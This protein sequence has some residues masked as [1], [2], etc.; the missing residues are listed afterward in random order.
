MSRRH[1]RRA[2]ALVACALAVAVPSRRLAAQRIELTPFAGWRAFGD[3]S[4]LAITDDVAFGGLVQVL[5]RSGRAGVEFLYSRQSTAFRAQGQ[6]TGAV[7]SRVGLSVEHFAVS[8][9]LRPEADTSARGGYA[10]FGAGW[11]TLASA[12]YGTVTRPMVTFGAGWRV[13]I[14]P[15]V[16]LHTGVRG[17]LALTSVNDGFGCR[18]RSSDGCVVPFGSSMLFQGE[19]FLGASVGF[20]RR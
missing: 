16:A 10:S 14:V 18:G 13:P 19:A 5:P 12:G 4:D 11:S 3:A 2:A 15:L 9:V 7:P 8:A 1:V 6:V 20:D 17:Y